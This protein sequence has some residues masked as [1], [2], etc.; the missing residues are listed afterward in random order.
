MTGVVYRLLTNLTYVACA[1]R[2]SRSGSVCVRFCVSV[3]GESPI[4]GG[5]GVASFFFG[6][7]WGGGS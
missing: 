7:E 4:S 6:S 5:G 1:I 3:N 2:H